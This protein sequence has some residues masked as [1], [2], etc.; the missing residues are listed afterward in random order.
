MLSH[1]VVLIITGLA[2]MHFVLCGK[3]PAYYIL[4]RCYLATFVFVSA[5]LV[6]Y[7]RGQK[8]DIVI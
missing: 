1:T 7:R 6:K 3:N 4:H 8:L 5:A 2:S